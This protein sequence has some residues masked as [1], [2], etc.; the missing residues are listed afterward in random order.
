ME[1]PLDHLVQRD[2]HVVPE[3]V[4]PE[5]IVGAVG[6][7]RCIGRLPGGIIHI[8]D[9]QPYRKAQE[10]VH[11]AHIFAVPAGQVVVDGDH[12]DPFPFQGIQIGRQGSHQGLPFTGT[13]LGDV[14]PVED[15]APDQLHIEMAQPQHPA[16]SFPDHGEGFRQQVVQGL[17][18]GQA[19]LEFLGLGTQTGIAEAG[20]F[21]FQRIDL[22]HIALA[23]LQFFLIGVPKDQFHQVFQQVYHSSI[24]QRSRRKTIILNPFFNC[25][26]CVYESQ[27]ESGQ[28][29]RLFVK[30]S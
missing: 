6:D 13:H 18:F 8:V 5:F 12:M 15:T 14:P 2:H 25:N 28:M 26:K 27:K 10:P 19:Q 7:V 17:P 22:I 4:E 20:H 16:G 11:P 9:D 23:D 21:R 3:V 1:R 29:P 30:I 24:L